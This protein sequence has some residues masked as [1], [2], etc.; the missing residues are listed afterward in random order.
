[1]SSN[2][3]K[4]RIDAGEYYVTADELADTMI[5]HHNLEEEFKKA[6]RARNLYIFDCILAITSIAFFLWLILKGS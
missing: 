4:R 3:L 1:M 2:E 6:S 5:E